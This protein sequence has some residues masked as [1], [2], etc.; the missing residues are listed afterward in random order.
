MHNEF[1]GK[2][3]SVEMFQLQRRLK[4]TEIKPAETQLW[5]MLHFLKFTVKWDFY[6]SVKFI[7]MFKTF[8]YSLSVILSERKFSKLKLRKTVFHGL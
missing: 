1:S 4:T 6:V 5:R 8:P 2:S 7:F 3:I